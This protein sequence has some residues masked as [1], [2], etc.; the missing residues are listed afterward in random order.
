MGGEGGVKSS[1]Q[2]GGEKNFHGGGGG[3]GGGGMG[4]WGY[5]DEG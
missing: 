3:V 1:V 2:V 4:V 5:E